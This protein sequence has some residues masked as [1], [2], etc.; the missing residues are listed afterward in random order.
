MCCSFL[1]LNRSTL[2]LDVFKLI[3]FFLYETMRL[4]T[5]ESILL[6]NATTPACGFGAHRQV[7]PIYVIHNKKSK[8]LYTQTQ[9]NLPV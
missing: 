2:K 5:E 6:K 9:N 8:M 1:F 7:P 3:P 4:S